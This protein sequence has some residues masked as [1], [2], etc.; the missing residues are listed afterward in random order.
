M[1]IK[2]S[3]RIVRLDALAERLNPQ[4]APATQRPAVLAQE[5][6]RLGWGDE[7]WDTWT[8]VRH[9]CPDSELQGAHLHAPQSHKKKCCSARPDAL[10]AAPE[11]CKYAI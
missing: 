11:T 1:E 8:A 4:M 3:R 6:G 10:D 9:R 7:P 2:I 5:L